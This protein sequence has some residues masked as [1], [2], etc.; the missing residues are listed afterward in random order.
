MAPRKKKNQVPSTPN[1][2]TTHSQ[3]GAF[4]PRGGVLL[5]LPDVNEVVDAVAEIDTNSR[6]KLKKDIPPAPNTSAKT[7]E[8]TNS[9]AKDL[10]DI[11]QNLDD[12]NNL[13]TTS[14]NDDDVV[15]CNDD[16]NKEWNDDNNNEDS[17]KDLDDDNADD[18]DANDDRL[19]EDAS[20]GDDSDDNDTVDDDG[21]DD[22]DDDD[23]DLDKKPKAATII[24]MK[25]AVS[26]AK[27][28]FSYDDDYFA[29]AGS[30]SNDDISVTKKSGRRQKQ[31]PGLP[32]LSPNASEKE[33]KARKKLYD[34]QCTQCLKEGFNNSNED[35]SGNHTPTIHTMRE[36][37]DDCLSKGQSF[38]TRKILLL[39][40]KEEANLRGISIRI[41]K[42]DNTKV[43]CW[44][45]ETTDFY[46]FARQS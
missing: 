12:D 7:N 16:A 31:L 28:V 3:R 30:D 4:Q 23:D 20:K 5:S 26:S 25:D 15:A 24:G 45:R 36:V 27:L 42:S 39:R 9:N 38:A 11:L 37:Q 33:H 2:V 6:D 34:R 8:D 46:V 22:D 29:A 43:V 10:I 40:V 32:P 41:E 13:G 18:A 44:S 21:G 17:D 14:H 35:L 1:R 19:D